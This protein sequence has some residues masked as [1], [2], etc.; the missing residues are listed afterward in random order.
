MFTY[1]VNADIELRLLELRHGKELYNVINS[2]R[3]YLR[4]FL[5]WVDS[6]KTVEQIESFVKTTLEQYASGHGFHAGIW[7]QGQFAGII[8]YHRINWANKNTSIGYWLGE[9]FQGRGIMSNCCA[10]L[11]DYGFNTLGLHRI[12]IR[13]ATANSK[14]QAIPKRLGFTKE[15]T[16]R[17]AE[18]LYDHYVDHDVYGL[19]AKEWKGNGKLKSS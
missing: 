6:N 13:C 4:E 15:G 16:I 10:A 3:P 5:P 11:V 12:E 19:L 2:C 7:Y 9:G 14:S 1:K 8:A 17:E 18:W